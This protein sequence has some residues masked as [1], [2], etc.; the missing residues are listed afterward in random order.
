M[1]NINHCS[2]DGLK[3]YLS[4]T[5]NGNLECEEV[6]RQTLQR[7]GQ[8]INVH[9]VDE[10]QAPLQRDEFGTL[11]WHV[12]SW[13]IIS[14][15]RRRCDYYWH[16]ISCWLWLWVSGTHQTLVRHIY[17]TDMRAHNL[18]PTSQPGKISVSELQ[19]ENNDMKRDWE[20]YSKEI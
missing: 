9:C 1:F 17:F 4:S 18:W 20:C 6:G 19:D 7:K 13:W 5:N 15:H 3:A 11:V 12:W 2:N 16:L 14:L 10:S 8:V